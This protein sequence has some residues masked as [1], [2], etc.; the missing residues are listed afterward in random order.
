MCYRKEVKKYGRRTKGRKEL[1]KHLENKRITRQQ[2]IEAKC[3]ECMGF[4]ADGIIDCGISNCP[5]YPYNPN[6]KANKKI[7]KE[8]RE[9]KLNKKE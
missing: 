2:A 9:K 4:Y 1:L 7:Q 6:S 8:K 5:L 3:Y